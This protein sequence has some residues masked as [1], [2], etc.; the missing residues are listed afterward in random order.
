MPDSPPTNETR[1]SERWRP[2]L[3]LGLI[4]LSLVAWASWF[5]YRTSFRVGD[6]RVF[7]LFDDAMISMTYAR[8]VVEGWGLNWARFGEPVEGFTCPLWVAAMVPVNL[9]PVSLEVRS[10][11]VQLLSLC[12]LMVMLLLVK[13]L[14]TGHFGAP[15]R[16]HWVPAVVL[17]AGYYP[18]L[19]WSLMG[20][21]TAL[22]AVLLV[23]M[24]LTTL[25]ITERRRP[26]HV[27]FFCLAS[28]AYLTRM[29]MLLCV[30]ICVLFL[31]LTARPRRETV[32]SW[33]L[34]GA[35]FL[36]TLVSYQAFRWLYFHDVLPNT[37][38]LKLSGIP[39]HLRI[40][41]G[42]SVLP[43]FLISHGW[44][45]GICLAGM[46]FVREKRRTLLLP[47]CIVLAYIAYSV[48]VGGD[49][50]EHS[51][52]DAN[53]FVAFALP[54]VFVVFTGLANRLLSQLDAG[55]VLGREVGTKL[56]YAT[57]MVLA[58]I[59]N[60][61]LVNPESREKWQAALVTERPFL[62]TSHHLVA[63]ETL[64]LKKRFPSGTRVATAWSGI[65][66]YFTDFEMVDVLGYNDPLIAHLDPVPSLSV[67]TFEKITPGH[68]KWNL[69]LTIESRRPQV[70]Y[71]TW[72]YTEEQL[73]R[74]LPGYG[75]QPDGSLWIRERSTH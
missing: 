48:Y 68:M 41:R 25:D 8:N 43:D 51:P 6:S 74:I 24:V 75:Y 50:W 58:L 14:V 26:R 30:G 42:L 5:I 72:G 28:L 20:M 54:L 44:I 69:N 11:F 47:L 45:L 19:Y 61:L 31:V 39:L 63:T 13:R 29:D 32:R 65:P 23:A 37:Y 21:E 9:L 66:A 73:R 33:V 49:A 53:R 62:V 52:I 22:Q 70:F 40:L 10:L 16:S 71:Q 56:L 57:T 38:Y 60:G 15:T 35:I 59:T 12:L 67:D 2:Q 34:G 1:L 4:L 46:L 7:C 64:S 3:G 36:G 27:L 55:R 17:T 18:L